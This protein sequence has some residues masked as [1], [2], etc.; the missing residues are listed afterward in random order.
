MSEKI[1]FELSPFQKMV[2]NASNCGDFLVMGSAFIENDAFIHKFNNDLVREALFHMQQ[3][4]P[5]LRA[6]LD[7]QQKENLMFIKLDNEN[8]EE[9]IELEWLDLSKQVDENQRK[10]AID[11]SARFDSTLFKYENKDLL[12]KTQ[13]ITY[14]ENSMIK[15]LINLV[16]HIAITDGI[17]IT[18]LTIEL[19][20]IINAL[21]TE[22]E[23][24][25]M[26]IKLEPVENLHVIC[27]QRKLFKESHKE[28]IQKLGN[29]EKVKFNLAD[30]LGSNKETGF[31]LDLFK[32][33]KELTTNI[34]VKS[35]PHKVRLTGYF[36]TAALYAMRDLYQEN[37]LEFPKRISIE[38]PASLRVRYEPN[39]EFYHCGLHTVMVIFST[40]ED[41]FGDFKDFWRD[42]KYV[43]DKIHEYTSA[44][45]GSLFSM[46]HNEELDEF[47]KVF[48]NTQSLQEAKNILRDGVMCDIAV[49]NLGKFVNDTVSVFPGPFDIK[50]VYCTDPLNSDPSISPAIVIH[51]FFWRGEIMIELG[52]NK[53]S[54]GTKY[55]NRYKELFLN[56]LNSSLN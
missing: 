52:A 38:I 10:R 45:T 11:E 7:I 15:Y 3:R 36:Q 55:F 2:V 23:C 42:A 32:L 44:E 8:I 13:V 29:L 25:E 16:L 21:I 51:L 53:W 12:W 31:I 6:Y 56:T 22:K 9:K 39:L 48:S 30:E 43:H 54:I 4:H 49:S 19:V 26:K 1:I 41:K 50:E 27:D 35:K 37:G 17:N 33:D 20:N 46:T 14:K 18:T 5:F 40:E 34:I 47:N 28:T 24:D